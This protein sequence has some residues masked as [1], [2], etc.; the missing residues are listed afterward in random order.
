MD[1]LTY[2]Q[3]LTI[4]DVII[5]LL[6]GGQVLSF[7]RKGYHAIT[8]H[9]DNL[10]AGAAYQALVDKHEQEIEAIKTSYEEEFKAIKEEFNKLFKTVKEEL[11]LLTYES[12]R[13]RRISLK[14]K[15]F[16]YWRDAMSRGYVT[17]Y[18][19][20]MFSESFEEFDKLKEYSDGDSEEVAKYKEEFYKLPVKA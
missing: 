7:L 14:T 9:H 3:Q 10:Q 12:R 5:I 15:I 13:Y 20:K 19:L 16:G 2:I 1:L 17:T 11:K 8:G 18:D 4:G 6:A